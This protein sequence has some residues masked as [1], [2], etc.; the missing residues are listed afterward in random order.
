MYRAVP[1]IVQTSTLDCG[2]ACLAMV[3]A[4]HGRRVPLE[5]LRTQLGMTRSG[6]SVKALLEIAESYDLTGSGWWVEDAV[7]LKD[8]MLPG[9]AHWQGQHFVVVEKVR[10]RSVTVIDPAVGRRD[11][12]L[13]E[14]ALGFQGSIVTLS[15]GENFRTGGDRVASPWRH[16]MR[17]AFEQ[18]RLLTEIFSL[19]LLVQLVALTLPVVMA[20]CIDSVIPRADVDLFR[21]IAFGLAAFTVA[22]LVTNLARQWFLVTLQERLNRKLLTRFFSHL[23]R[24]PLSFFR[25]RGSGDL[26]MR[27]NSNALIQEALSGQMLRMALDIGFALFYLLAVFFRSPPLAAVICVVAAVQM[28][29]A[30][31]FLRK[32]QS[33]V[34]LENLTQVQSQMYA[35]E[36]I[37]GIATVKSAGAEA[38]VLSCWSGHFEKHLGASTAL[39]R[40][41]LIGEGALAVLAQSAPVIL[42]VFGTALVLNG[43]LS[44]GSMIAFNVLAAAFFSP[45]ASF[46]DSL[47]HLQAIRV[48]LIRLND[49]LDADA[50]QAASIPRKAELGGHLSL[51]GVSFRYSAREADVLRDIDLDILPGQM[52]AL[53]GRSGSGKS[54]LAHILAALCAPTKGTFFFGD[55]DLQSL[56]FNSV[57]RQM[58]VVLQESFLFQETI[59]ANIAFGNPATPH[60]QI[61]KA[62][63][64]AAIDDDIQ[65]MP[66]K[67]D[68]L[69]G[70]AGANI[71]GGQRQRI[72]LARALLNDPSL[73]ILDEATSELD[74]LSEKAIQENL[75]R[76]RCTRV[77]VAHRLSTV[78]N[79]DVIVVLDHGR[80]VE[81][82]T[83][84]E[85]LR[86][87]GIYNDLVAGQR[88]EN[89][90]IPNLKV[91]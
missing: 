55:T 18:K 70:E 3:L 14:F 91:V 10:G 87:G 29:V 77:I 56:D 81:K 54:T 73:L 19:S 30:V 17:L 80:I 69:L 65:A 89:A 68:T 22:G 72:C 47:K 36:A 82:G 48:S 41:S 7:R 52:V 59:A 44:L 71:S 1:F 13:D 2:A 45:W 11:L 88:R 40:V 83:H 21:S 75:S 90:S 23:L 16:V 51:K 66:L 42:L 64:I 32:I 25:L 43:S 28:A 84:D 60:H 15:P 62:A 49:V 39:K 20:I 38:D 31:A 8:L 33:H 5:T 46:V 61:V 35:G 58:G 4:F 74:A 63:R 24:L 12:T 85:L 57:R 79:A 67:Y 76:L 9:I 78:R 6:V 26:L 53:V 27:L 37:R 50:E 86:A 34:Q